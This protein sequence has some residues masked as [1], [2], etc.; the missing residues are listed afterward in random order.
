MSYLL[1]IM[2]VARVCLTK[3]RKLWGKYSVHRSFANRKQ[4]TKQNNECN[5]IEKNW[6][7][8]LFVFITNQWLWNIKYHIFCM[9]RIDQ[10]SNS[11]KICTN[12]RFRFWG[13][14]S[15]FFDNAK[16]WHEALQSYEPT[17]W[18]ACICG[19]CI[20]PKIISKIVTDPQKYIVMSHNISPKKSKTIDKWQFRWT[21]LF[22][23]K[24]R[25]KQIEM[26]KVTT[27]IEIKFEKYRRFQLNLWL[28]W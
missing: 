6:K 5:W 11:N 9:K 24:I 21:Q 8:Y 1:T 16:C 23:K 17:L 3:H 10:R 7:K 22:L 4:G 26:C 13:Y 25:Q 12:S 28:P 20:M 27:Q 2:W 19:A 18:L 14:A 15:V